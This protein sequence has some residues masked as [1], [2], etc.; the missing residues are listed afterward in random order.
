MKEPIEKFVFAESDS[1]EFATYIIEFMKEHT[2]EDMVS[3]VS[4]YVD[5]IAE[6]KSSN[7]PQF[8]SLEKVDDVVQIVS[9]AVDEIDYKYVGY[10]I[11]KNASEAAQVKYGENHLKL[12]IQM[13]LVSDKPYK[14]TELGKCYLNIAEDQR[15]QI[16]T[17]LFFRIPIIQYLLT[18]SQNKIID[19]MDVL[20]SVL[21]EKT[22]VRRRS[23][24]KAIIKEIFE[25]SSL[26]LQKQ[27]MN[28]IKW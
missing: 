14:I 28:N 3:V 20:K 24:T 8:S 19:G 13:G 23:N 26:D 21:S 25:L 7:I 18:R 9:D 22:A 12:A 2:I 11:N 4:K 10:M 1:D 5:K 16:R 17:K 27:I 15:E 6:L